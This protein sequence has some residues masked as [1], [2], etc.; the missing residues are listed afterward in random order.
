MG[1]VK[2]TSVILNEDILDIAERETGIY[3][4]SANYRSLTNIE[5]GLKP[6]HRRILYSMFDMKL[7]P[8]SG[9]AKVARV[10]GIVLGRFHPH[11]QS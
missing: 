1:K 11:G 2:D 3:A 6:V 10:I 8:G 5:D 7:L 4:G 9:F